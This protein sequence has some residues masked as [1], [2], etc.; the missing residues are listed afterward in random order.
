MG[1]WRKQWDVEAIDDCRNT[2]KG[3]EYRVKWK[4]KDGGPS[5]VTYS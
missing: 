3:L 1:D 2:M 5:D 4:S